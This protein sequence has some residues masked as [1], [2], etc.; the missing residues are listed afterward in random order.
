MEGSVL[1]SKTTNVEKVKNAQLCTGCG[2]CVSICPNLAIQMNVTSEGIY[3]PQIELSKCNSCG[4]CFDTCPGHSLDFKQFN[5]QIFSTEPDP[6]IGSY[7]NCYIGHSENNDVRYNSSSGGLVTQLLIYALERGIIDGALVTKMSVSDPLKPYPFI[8]RTK[9]EIIDADK[10]KYC[11]VPVNSSIREILQA[12]EDE[13]FAIVGLPCQIQGIRKAEMINS[14]LRKRVVLHLGLF[15]NHTP[16]FLA[17]KFLL[18]NLNVNASDIVHLDYRG[19]G[20]PGG[21]S[22]SLKNGEEVFIPHFSP[23][24]WGVAFNLFFFPTHCILCSD[25]LCELADI[26]FGDA[27]LPKL[28][29]DKQGTSLIIIRNKIGE[30]LLHNGQKAGVIAL[31]R[32]SPKAV[33][34]SQSIFSVKKRRKALKKLF[35]FFG[36]PIQFTNQELPN[37]KFSDY[38]FSIL[39][40]CLNFSLSRVNLWRFTKSFSWLIGQSPLMK[41]FTVR[42]Y[43]FHD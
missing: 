43:Y 20:W 19:K 22:I 26:S 41:I 2:T 38:L 16:T 18:S 32:V 4:N 12:K 23:I 17:T 13:T 40:Y 33:I 24:Y 29:K 39:F 31:T 5:A 25:K 1:T 8:A 9:K 15:C 37:P 28:S 14:N 10:S 6:M 7:L 11:P 36:K 34:R 30:K 3:L 42:G 27:W 21:M 35:T